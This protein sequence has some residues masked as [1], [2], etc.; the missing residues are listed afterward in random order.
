MMRYTGHKRRPRVR[1]W[2]A[3][4]ACVIIVA[5]VWRDKFFEKFGQDI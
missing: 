5:L 2:L 3:L 4:I 1:C